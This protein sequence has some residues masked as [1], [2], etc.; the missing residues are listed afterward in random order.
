MIEFNIPNTH[1][2][3]ILEVC[4]IFEQ[5]GPKVIHCHHTFDTDTEV[6]RESSV[7]GQFIKLCKEKNF[8]VDSQIDKWI[9]KHVHK[10]V[11]DEFLPCRKHIFNIGEL[12]PIVVN[13]DHFLLASFE[14]LR[15]FLDTGAMD[16][17]SYINFLDN[18]W[19]SLGKQGMDKTALNIPAFGNRI[20][21]VANNAFTID[22]K[23]GLIVQSYFKAMKTN[24]LFETLRICIHDYDAKNLDLQKW[25]DILLPYMYQFCQLPLGVK[26][27]NSKQKGL[28]AGIEKSNR[29]LLLKSYNKVKHDEKLIFISHSKDDLQEADI[30]YDY[31]E[32]QGYKCWM[33]THDITPGIPY[34][35]EI[36]KGFNESDAVVV[37]ISKNTLRSV[38][39]L[40]EIDNVYKR[41]KI[42]IPFIIEELQMSDEM[43]FYLSRT[44]WILAHPRFDEHL[45]DLGKALCQLLK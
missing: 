39:V 21:N 43:S 4:N 3:I 12:C 25:K 18:L 30:V 10:S 2:R 42:I 6:M 20:V 16:L 29:S 8:D 23:I 22:Q 33:D 7:M 45:D 14:N 40:N 26:T 37:V 15:T 28:Y 1:S 19:K 36:M 32:S 5:E 11:E 38:G 34:A 27:L 35:K 24:R 44:Q 13:E 17:D 31:L 41:N 9:A